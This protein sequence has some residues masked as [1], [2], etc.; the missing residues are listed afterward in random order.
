MATSQNTTSRFHNLSDAALADELGRVDAI[1]KAAE[2]E[3]KALKDEFKARGLCAARRRLHGDCDRAD[4][5]T[6]RRQGRARLP[7]RGLFAFRGRRRLDRD[8]DQGRQPHAAD[9]G[10]TFS[11]IPAP[12][13]LAGGVQLVQGQ[14][15][16]QRHRAGKRPALTEATNRRAV[17]GAVLAGRCR[18]GRGAALSRKWR[19][20]PRRSIACP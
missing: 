10:L 18:C 17:L 16:D 13:A 14:F 6:S 2:I 15:D 7:G 9:R 20:G 4:R 3:L 12:L 11:S 19:A 1:S 5:R 8:P